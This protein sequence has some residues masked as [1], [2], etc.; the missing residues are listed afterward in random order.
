[1][2]KLDQYRQIVKELLQSLAVSDEPE[3]E[4]QLICDIEQDHYQIVEVGWQGLKRIYACYVHIDIKE[5]KIWIQHNMTEVDLGQALVDKGIPN[6]DIILGLQP[7][8]KRPYT[9]YGVA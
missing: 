9:N 8:Y 6:S 2:A 4:C 5:Q 3:I 1:M 7:S